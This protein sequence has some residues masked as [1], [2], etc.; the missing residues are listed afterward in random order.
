MRS[1]GLAQLMNILTVWHSS[2]AMSRMHILSVCRAFFESYQ[3]S[4]VSINDPKS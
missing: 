1:F 3:L 4:E 2:F